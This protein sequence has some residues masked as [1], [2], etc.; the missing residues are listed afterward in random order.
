[1][2]RYLVRSLCLAV[3]RHPGASLDPVTHAL[4]DPDEWVHARAQEVFEGPWRD[5][6]PDKKLAGELETDVV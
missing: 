4:V 5:V 2:A 1:M 3:A 6:D